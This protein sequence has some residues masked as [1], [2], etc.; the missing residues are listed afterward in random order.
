V[1]FLTFEEQLISV[2]A[3]PKSFIFERV[4]FSILKN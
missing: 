1:F 2:K 4:S 3:I